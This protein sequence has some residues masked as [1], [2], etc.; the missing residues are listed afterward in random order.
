ML[1]ESGNESLI[2]VGAGH[3]E[4]VGGNRAEGGLVQFLEEPDFISEQNYLNV[5]LEKNTANHQFQFSGDYSQFKAKQHIR[6]AAPAGFFL[7]ELQQM[8]INNRI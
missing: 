1:W 3:S 5:S 7:P 8:F 6:V 4:L 2:R